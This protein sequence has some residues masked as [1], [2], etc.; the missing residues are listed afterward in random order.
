M[1]T[2]PSLLEVRPLRKSIAVLGAGPG[3]GHA[4]ARRYAQAGYDVVLVARRPNPSNYSP[5]N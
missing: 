2:E 5:E 1:R 3:L 4:V